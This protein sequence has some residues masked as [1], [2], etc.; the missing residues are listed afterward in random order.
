MFANALH[1]N[2]LTNKSNTKRKRGIIFQSYNDIKFNAEKENKENISLNLIN[3]PIKPKNLDRRIK[4]VVGRTPL[5]SKS[6]KIIM[7]TENKYDKFLQ[8]GKSPFFVSDKISFRN[9][10]K[11]FKINNVFIKPK[12]LGLCDYYLKNNKNK[13]ISREI[14]ADH[15]FSKTPRFHREKS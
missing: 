4:F 9:E 2:N 3:T 1:K 13:A 12:H 6:K 14:E 7:F 11:S 10:F 8:R 15:D 5:I